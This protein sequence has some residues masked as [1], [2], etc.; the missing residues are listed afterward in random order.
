MPKFDTQL[1]HCQHF[2]DSNS[3]N[4]QYFGYGIFSW[5][6][7]DIQDVAQRRKTQNEEKLTM[8]C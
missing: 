6:K 5:F 3:L 4:R 2:P 8:F 1:S 7:Y